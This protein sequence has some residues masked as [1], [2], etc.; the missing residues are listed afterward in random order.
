MLYGYA[1]VSSST[2]NLDVQIDKLTEY[3]VDV[4]KIYK[5][6]KSGRAGSHRPSFNELLEVVEQGDT[7]VVTRLDRFARSTVDALK[8]IDY[9]DGKGANLVIL[10]V[11]GD[12]LDTSTPN[13]RL[14]VTVLSAV[15]QFEVDLSRDRQKE[16]IAAAKVRG[17]YKGRPKKY[18]KKHAGLQHAIKLYNQRDSNGYTVSEICEIT[19]IS[20]A[21]LYRN[22]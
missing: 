10:N 3:G 22:I 11:S 9:L 12:V 18:T 14:M 8:T 4:D 21:T 15:A 1:R 6:K 5:D 13:G 20:R 17:V 2:Q 16:G 19:S 7:I